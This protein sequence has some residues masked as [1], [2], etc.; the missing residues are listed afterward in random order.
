MLLR[1]QGCAGG[2]K[3]HYHS[4]NVKSMKNPIILLRHAQ[5]EYNQACSNYYDQNGLHG[6]TWEQACEIVDFNRTINYNSCFIDSS[7]TQEGILQ[8][9]FPLRS[10]KTPAT[11]SSCSLPSIWCW[12][13]LSEGRS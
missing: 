5:S 4:R 12:S 13:P 1:L 10:A 6:M 3:Y 8:V 2:L 7:I 9:G 11:S